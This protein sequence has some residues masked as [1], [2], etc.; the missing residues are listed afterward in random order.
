MEY[1]TMIGGSVGAGGGNSPDD[2]RLVQRLL[3]DARARKGGQ[4]LKVDGM[5][6]KLTDAAILH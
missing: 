5:A 6:G 4:K 1:G 2:V 3:N